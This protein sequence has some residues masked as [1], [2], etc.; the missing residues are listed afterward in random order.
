MLIISRR[1]SGDSFE[2]RAPFIMGTAAMPAKAC[3]PLSGRYRS[4]VKELWLASDP[5]YAA[6]GKVLAIAALGIAAKTFA[7]ERDDG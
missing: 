4:N 1:D 2:K 5:A 7:N 6:A 3:S